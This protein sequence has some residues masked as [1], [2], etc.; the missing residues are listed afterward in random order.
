MLHNDLDVV[1]FVLHKHK[2]NFGIAPLAPLKISQMEL[3]VL[4]DKRGRRDGGSEFVV[5]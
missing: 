4:E 1:V 3:Q 2:I 5:E